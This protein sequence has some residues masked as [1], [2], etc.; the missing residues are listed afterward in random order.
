MRINSSMYARQRG[1]IMKTRKNLWGSL[2]ISFGWGMVFILLEMLQ[3]TSVFGYA[4]FILPLVGLFAT[5][6]IL[7]I[8]QY[9]PDVLEK[10][11]VRRPA[12]RRVDALLSRLSDDELD[13]LRDRLSDQRDWGYD[14]L[15]DLLV[16]E[17]DKRKNY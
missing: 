11:E 8:L 12:Q 2:I 4:L 17:R 1:W 14:S 9:V 10:Q 5:Y 6:Q 16:E 7:R 3:Y 15:G 13:A